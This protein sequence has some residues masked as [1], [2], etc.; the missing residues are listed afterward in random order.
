MTY[1]L[2]LKNAIVFALSCDLFDLH[3]WN[4]NC[5]LQNLEYTFDMKSQYSKWTRFSWTMAY[6]ELLNDKS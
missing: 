3:R 5:Y 6:D 1:V 4:A 2:L